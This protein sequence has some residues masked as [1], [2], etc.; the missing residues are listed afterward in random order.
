MP[1]APPPMLDARKPQRHRGT[2]EE[3]RGRK[4]RGAGPPAHPKK[5]PQITQIDTDIFFDAD[6]GSLLNRRDRASCTSEFLTQRRRGAETQRVCL[7][8]ASSGE[9][10]AVNDGQEPLGQA[11]ATEASI[12]RSGL[13]QR[14]GLSERRPRLPLSS[15]TKWE[16][17]VPR[18]KT[19]HGRRNRHAVGVAAGGVTGL[20]E[21]SRSESSGASPVAGDREIAGVSA[22]HSRIDA[23]SSVMNPLRL[24][25]S[26][27][28]RSFLCASVPS[29]LCVFFLRVSSLCLCVSV[30]LCPGLVGGSNI[31][32]I[33]HRDGDGDGHG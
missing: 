9:V 11:R 13:T 32:S 5:K 29:R 23:S 2:E 33:G 22:G 19:E 7:I 20:D 12:R 26:A 8:A 28:L 25:A 24:R 6:C 16:Q 14:P 1:P 18:Q 15:K 31:S 3:H 17:T 4:R 27:P 21:R 10:L 30:V